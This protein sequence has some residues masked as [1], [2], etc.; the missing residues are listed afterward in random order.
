MSPAPQTGRV[1]LPL[2]APLLAAGPAN[3]RP[4]P[5]D[6]PD[7]PDTPDARAQAWRCILVEQSQDAVYVLDEQGCV[8]EANA[9]FARLL[10]CSAEAAL[11]LR[12][13][14]WDIDFPQA[15][16]SEVLARTEPAFA[17]FESRWQRTDGTL[18]LV[19]S[20]IH[21]TQRPV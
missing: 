20:R 9:S 7:P 6:P 17:S 1:T 11:R 13:W 21:R 18:R 4:D 16:A 12:W 14:Q 10:G 3:V 8:L 2:S 5:P 19:E 15:R